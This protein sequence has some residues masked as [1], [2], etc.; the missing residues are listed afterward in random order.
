MRQFTLTLILVLFTFTLLFSEVPVDNKFVKTWKISDKF[1]TVDSIPVDTTHLNFQDVNAID[2][3]SIA[4]SFNGNL[5]SALQSK[6]YFDRPNSTDFM[7]SDAYYPYI[8]QIETATFYNTKT[9]FSYLKYLTG[10]TNF[11]EE[12]QIAFLFTANA[13][14]D[15]NFGTTLDYIYARGEYQKQSVKRFSGSIFGSYN[16]KKYSATGLI[17]TNDYNSIENGGITESSYLT[18]PPYGYTAAVNFP[19][20][21]EAGAQSTYKHLQAHYNQQYS[22]GFERKVKDA[23]DSTEMEF[24]PVTRFM[25]TFQ[26]DRMSRRYYESTVEKKFYKNTYLPDKLTNDSNSLTKITNRLSVNLAEEF[27][28]WMQFGL[29]AYLENDIEQFGYKV[30]STM[31][32]QNESNTKLGGILSKE[33]GQQF[34][35]RFLGELNFAGYKAGD[36]NLEARLGG[37]FRLWKDTI[38]LHANGFVNS[39]EPSF[40]LKNYDSNH[41]RWDNEF[42]KTYKTHVGGEFSIPTRSLSLLVNLENI[43]KQVYF[44]SIALPAQFDGNVQ[45]I[46]AQLKLDF[47]VGKFTLENNIVYQLSSNQEVIPL[48]TV[49]LFHNLYF[50]DKWFDVLSVQ[51][52]TNVRFHSAYNAPGY[53][54]ATGQFYNQNEMSI[55]NYPVM[56]A[57][58]NFH[59]K[60]TRFYV[61][62]YHV[63]QLFMKGIYYS[64]PYYPIN[65]AVFKMGL[66]WNFYD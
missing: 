46:S 35:Y 62:Y 24:I 61:E 39:A 45:V 37:F 50:H 4:N 53:M 52:G 54:P 42:T 31:M 63:N 29:T 26:L 3:F 25:H 34:N 5:G 55:G 19:V 1:G 13:N 12:D 58:A 56:N 14:K 47:H 66:T 40:F 65:P 32:H 10:G 27:N 6:L 9:P 30:D 49:T 7:F 2:R 23:K 17:A 16:G 18:N 22:L 20:N 33:R 60:R 51:L 48:P 57:Y 11:R 36:F 28:K 21:I 8:N 44:D 38:A 64:M 59:L 43:S 41:F 15:L